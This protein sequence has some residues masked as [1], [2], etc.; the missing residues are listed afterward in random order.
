MSLP[1]LVHFHYEEEEHSLADLHVSAPYFLNGLI[2]ANVSW[3][4]APDQRVKQYDIH[5]TESACHADVLSCCYARD[6]ATTQRSFQL[7]DL[8]YNCS[9]RVIVAPVGAR[10]KKIFEISFNVSSC[11]RTDVY[12][13]VRPPCQTTDRR[14]GRT[15]A[16]D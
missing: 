8:R 16:I 9:Y 2:K 5:W 7:Y 11:E 6:A 14:T 1:A 13:S 12:G 15:N 3:T 4:H 10:E